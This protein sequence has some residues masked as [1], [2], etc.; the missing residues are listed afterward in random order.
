MKFPAYKNPV[1]FYDE[2][3]KQKSGKHNAAVFLRYECGR[4]Y[5]DGI[6]GGEEDIWREKGY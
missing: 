2:S 4:L 6:T 5:F 3:V 1:Y